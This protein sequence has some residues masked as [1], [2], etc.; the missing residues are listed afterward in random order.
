MTDYVYI[1]DDHF[2]ISPPELVKR[3]IVKETAKQVVLAKGNYGGSLYAD[4]YSKDD[5]R[6]FR[7]AEEAWGAYI[8]QTERLLLKQRNTMF[9]TELHLTAAKKAYRELGAE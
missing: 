9:Q 7:S 5:R 2:G 8:T 3:A 1:V 4:H 6:I